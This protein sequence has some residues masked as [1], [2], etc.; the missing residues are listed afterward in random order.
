MRAFI[1]CR[2]QVPYNT[3]FYSAWLGFSDMGFEIVPYFEPVELLGARR[4]D[5]VVGGIG[6]CHAVMR[7][8]GVQ[9]PRINYPE[10]LRPFLGRKLWQSTIDQVSNDPESWPLFVKP[11]EDKRFTGK[12]ILGI[13]D[14]VGCGTS[15]ENP[16][17]ICSEVVDFKAEWRCFVRYREILDVRPYKGDWRLHFDPSIIERAVKDYS[18]APAGYGIDFGVTG[19]GR[20]LLVEVNDGYALG[21]YGLQHDLY[22][23]LLAARWS[24]LMGVDDELAYIGLHPDA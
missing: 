2:Q 16:E 6:S 17:V 4:E 14:L 24:E 19:D 9:I 18:D 11:V 13:S 12:A 20:T 3:N 23:Q 15:G 5:V 21:S 1:P 10:S 8:L 22:A 7:R